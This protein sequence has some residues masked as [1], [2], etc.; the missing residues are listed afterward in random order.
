MTKPRKG[1]LVLTKQNVRVLSREEVDEVV[2]GIVIDTSLTNTGPIACCK[3]GTLLQ[4]PYTKPPPT[5][6][7]CPEC[8][9]LNS[10]LLSPYTS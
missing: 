7:G 4:D 8:C 1:R 2:G 6:G 10:V 3:L 5:A 9:R